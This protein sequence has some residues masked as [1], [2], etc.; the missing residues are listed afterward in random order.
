[1]SGKG[2]M[3]PDVAV[4]GQGKNGESGA[5]EMSHYLP[6][7]PQSQ[8]LNELAA[9]SQWTAWTWGKPDPTTGKRGKI[10]INPHT[11]EAASSTDPETWGTYEE[12]QQAAKT[13][14][15][16]GIGF[17]LTDEDPFVAFDLDHVLRGDPA[18]AV[19][20]KEYGGIYLEKSPSGDG[21][22]GICKGRVP[23][24]ARNKN[25]NFEIYDHRRF[26]TITGEVWGE[27]EEIR[28]KQEAIEWY[29]R[30]YTGERTMEPE[31]S[32]ETRTTP[33]D[34]LERRKAA[35]RRDEKLLKLFK[36][37]VDYGD[38]GDYYSP[39]EAD[40][41]LASKI[42]FYLGPDPDAIEN[43]AKQSALYR[44]KW[45]RRDGT[46]GSYIRRTI[47]T[48][49][50][51]MDQFYQ[52]PRQGE[53]PG[54]ESGE[55]EQPRT[56]FP[57]VHVSELEAKAPEWVVRDLIEADC[58]AQVFGD[59]GSGKSF[60]GVDLGCTVSTG[61]E[62]HGKG[63]RQG[64]VIYLA[65]EGQNG[66]A[67]RLKAWE[68]RNQT[69]LQDA[70]LY[71][72]KKPA[73][74]SAPEAAELVVQ[75]VNEIGQIE[76]PQLVIVDTV[77]RNFGPGDENSTRDMNLFVDALDKIREQ[78]N[79]TILL[80][81]HT[82]HA[83]KSRARGAMALKGAVDVEYR[84][85]KD[86]QGTVRLENVKMKDGAEPA[87]MAFKIRE[88]ELGFRDKQGEEVTSAILDPTDYEAPAKQTSS[89]R[90]K[91]QSIALKEL[92]RLYQEHRDR[93]ERGGFD[94]ESARV[95][96]QDWQE[97]CKQAGLSRQRFQE[98]KK[99]CHIEHGYVYEP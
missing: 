55:E 65:G 24:W 96:V 52:L 81:H 49:L 80:I 91:N 7:S 54:Q 88:V 56:R 6:P 53:E 20:L 44:E 58:I 23:E 74:L 3:A 77:A 33:E 11:G 9:Y 15:L 71:I 16:P 48:A 51:S 89:G 85:S 29:C 41:A 40:E 25:G 67:R 63:V 87:P 86:D 38:H 94:P 79:C 43:L 98:V 17:C 93:L 72:S 73:D 34:E 99:N 1:M 60:L 28:E 46:Y 22:R 5:M 14:N 95:T 39:S 21:L 45:D 47:N 35:A 76:K 37:Q 70:P 26:V 97:A 31:H 30:T 82:G 57:L 69:S 75:A 32:V 19:E 92:K 78:H 68:I 12:A 84:M 59:P 27:P 66:I 64:A 62:W 10:P 90:G 50:A 42:D 13:Y 8:A 2:K 18:P 61:T 4:Q 83:D 36:G